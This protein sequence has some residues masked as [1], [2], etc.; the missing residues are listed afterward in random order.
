MSVMPWVGELLYLQPFPE[1]MIQPLS[2][3]DMLSIAHPNID[4]APFCLEYQ[5]P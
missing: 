5:L 1:L 2:E 4:Y 3:A